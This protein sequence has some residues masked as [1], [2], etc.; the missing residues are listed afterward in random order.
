[1]KYLNI[2][3]INILL[4]LSS[5]NCVF[6]QENNSIYIL[7]KTHSP[8]YAEI[9]NDVNLGLGWLSI[10]ETFQILEIRNINNENKKWYKIHNEKLNIVWC[11]INPDNILD[12]THIDPA[13]LPMNKINLNEII[14]PNKTG[15]GNIIKITGDFKEYEYFYGLS[16]V[17]IECFKKNANLDEDFTDLQRYFPNYYSL[18]EINLYRNIDDFP[19]DGFYSHK[20][21]NYRNDI[22][23][24]DSFCFSAHDAYDMYLQRHIFS[25]TNDYNI[26]IAIYIPIYGRGEL[27][28]RKILVSEAPEYFSEEYG[29]IGWDY[30]NNAV[31]RFGNDLLNQN[32]NSSTATK[33]FRETEEIING[34]YIR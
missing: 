18:M 31:E 30:N 32:N 19:Y 10:G 34:L 2:I 14:I 5:I 29:D 28:L 16:K 6:S 26:K 1:M 23:F 15:R 33:W 17:S 21:R 20:R 13:Q 12:I 24:V 9:T 7:T 25:S 3:I 22:L 11:K 4:F 8:V 27:N